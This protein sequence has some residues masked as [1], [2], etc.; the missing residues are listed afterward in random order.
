MQRSEKKKK[1]ES[2]AQDMS[3]VLK[4]IQEADLL[5]KK[6]ACRSNPEKSSPEEKI[7]GPQKLKQN[8]QQILLEPQ[9][10]SAPV[11]NLC[12]DDTHDATCSDNESS[13][14]SSIWC[15]YSC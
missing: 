9:S 13:S 12:P 8:E 15:M 10:V 11:P 4:V 3:I 7:Q 2:A 14:S 5:R 6:T 1:I